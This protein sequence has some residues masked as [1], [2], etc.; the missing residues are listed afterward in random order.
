VS[1]HVIIDGHTYQPA[2]PKI[3]VAVTT[4]NRPQI[5]AATVKHIR[6]HTPAAA[7]IVVDD[8][9]DT[10]YPDADHRFDTRAGIATAKNKCLELLFN[11]H[12]V[13]HAFLFDDDCYP[14]TENW[15]EPYVNSPE[16]HLMYQFED[17]AGPRKIRDVTKIFDDGTHFALS[18]AR[19]CMIYVH[20]T[21]IDT[22]GGL[23]PDFGAWGWEHPSW[24]DRIFN[25][26][27]TTF[28]YGDIVGSNKLIHS[29]DE[30]EEVERSVSAQERQATAKKN[31]AL[32]W[33]HHYTSSQHIPISQ[34]RNTV[35]T[36]LL[37]KNPDPQRGTT[38]QADGKLLNTLLASIKDAESVVLCDNPV[39]AAATITQVQAPVKNPYFARW[40]LYYQWL[41]DHP[42]TQWVWCVDGTDVEMLNPPWQHMQ[43]GK[44]Y[45]GY[46]PTIVGIDWMRDNHEAKHLQDFFVSH[47]NETL[48]NA[49]VVGGDRDTIMGFAHDIIADHADQETR[50]WHKKDTPGAMVGD[51]AT[52]NYIARTK[53]QD[54]LV[55]GPQV[56]TTFKANERNAWS[57]WRHK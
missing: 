36:C 41:R 23:D 51:M 16:P 38:I 33:Q 26:G 46:E 19:G 57:W 25:A 53:Y 28:R 22:I 47:A 37:T 9:S 12:Q 27:L 34:P 21:V 14:T 35:L 52:L 4:R 55:C 13:E 6:T 49:G 44:L 31:V 17:L 24:S 20:R 15:W 56:T 54:R 11:H 29:M 3:G 7:I 10:P 8:A 2:T 43:P 18:G 45:V 42:D 48:L 40:Y 50:I 30:H 1:V 39:T 5:A 32:Y